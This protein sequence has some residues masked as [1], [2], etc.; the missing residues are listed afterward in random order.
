MLPEQLAIRLGH[1]SNSLRP[2][3][4]IEELLARPPFR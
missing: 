1:G 2:D 3:Q 4:P